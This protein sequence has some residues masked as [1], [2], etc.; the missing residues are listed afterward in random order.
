M[1]NSSN[2][3]WFLSSRRSRLFT[4]FILYFS[5][6]LPQGFAV[7]AMATWMRRSGIGPEAIGLF[8]AALYI[9]WSWKW[10]MGPVVDLV[11]PHRIGKSRF[12]I[13]IAQSIMIVTILMLMRVDASTS[14]GLA[15]ALMILHNTF[16]ALQDVAI[17]ALACKVLRP[18]ERG[19]ASGLM[20]A[21]AYL[22][23]AI[24]GAGVLTLSEY[25][26]VSI[27]MCVVPVLLA[28]IL[29]GV[30]IWLRESDEIVQDALQK[31]VPITLQVMTYARNMG[32]AFFGSVQG[33]MV[34][35]FAILPTGAFALS[36]ALQ[37]NLAVELG[38][39]DGQIG[40]MGL[41]SA[42]LA[43]GGCV[44]GGFLSDRFGRRKMI[45]LYAV[46][47][48]IPTFLYGLYMLNAGWF[49]PAAAGAASRA[50][51]EGMISAF[52][53]ASLSFSF[54]QGLLQGT[55]SALY[56]DYCNPAIAATQFTAYMAIQNFCIAYTS[57]WQGWAIARWGY[58][59]T[60]FLDAAVGCVGLLL[61]PFLVPV[62]RADKVLL[63][64]QP[65]LDPA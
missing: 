41:I 33:L 1:S 28:A 36:L 57:A 20:F 38:L 27:S 44:L 7:G 56:M 42:V 13:V 53:I 35:A 59:T 16:A 63:P 17:D 51:P 48:A 65:G 64:E 31:R 32:R 4:F 19:Y 11:N 29:C 60:L 50:V 47:T 62:T 8:V 12:W 6:G 45:A 10:V 34:L 52:W 37:S 22:G 18:S 61:L 23:S 24:G 54:M 55:S 21:G 30:S 9:P 58:P 39:T 15:I 43:A 5:E 49:F 25:V 14:M 40:R 46:G 26:G 3:S 2:E